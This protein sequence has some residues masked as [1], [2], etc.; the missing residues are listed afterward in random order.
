[1][2]FLSFLLLLSSL[3]FSA[4]PKITTTMS[5]QELNK[6]AASDGAVGDIFGC[7]V[8][9]SGDTAVVGAWG[10]D[11]DLY[12]ESGSAYIYERDTSTGLF[13]QV[14]KSILYNLANFQIQLKILLFKQKLRLLLS[15]MKPLRS[16][17]IKQAWFILMRFNLNNS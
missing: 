10:D 1:M 16:A 7:S 12:T 17:L 8:A 4:S 15:F 6:L 2:R 13:Q 14:A 3:L 5:M 9:I 11:G